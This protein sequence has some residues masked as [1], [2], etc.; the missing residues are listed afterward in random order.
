[1][2]VEYKLYPL[3]L[4]CI[5]RELGLLFD[6]ACPLNDPQASPVLISSHD[7]VQEEPVC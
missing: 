5:A 6:L 7:Q 2:R 3:P 1:M 4:V